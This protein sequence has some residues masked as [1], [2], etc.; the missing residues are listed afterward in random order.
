MRME[1]VRSLLQQIPC[2][3][4]MKDFLEEK[5]IMHG[6]QASIFNLKTFHLIANN[7]RIV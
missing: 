4:R 3:I 1:Y 6:K 2:G 5:F 7:I